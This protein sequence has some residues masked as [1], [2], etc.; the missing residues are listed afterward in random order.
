MLILNARDIENCAA[1]VDLV[2]AVEQAFLVQEDGAYTMPDRLHVEHGGN[3]L[4]AMPAFANDRFATKLVSVFPEST[5]A[6]QGALLLND[7]ADGRPLALMEGAVLT[8]LRTGAV[9]GLGIAHTT[10]AAAASLGLFGAGVQ[11]FRQVL[12]ACGVRP[13]GRVT[14]H[15]PHHP[16]LPGFLDRLRKRLP[17]VEF[18]VAEDARELVAASEIVI[19][20]TTSTTPVVPADP[21]LLAGRSYVGLGSFRPDMREFPDALME[22]L[23][24]VVVDTDLARSESGDLRIPLESGQLDSP[25][26]VRLGQ[27]IRGSDTLDPDGTTLFKTVG[28]ALCDLV[29]ARAL[30]RQ[31]LADGIGTTVAFP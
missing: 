18:G 23:D 24:R 2:A 11:G 25:K 9:S 8:A 15:D 7:G 1:A 12:F 6:I 16:D 27:V 17:G 22:V 28:M 5:P 21:A 14:V 19:T 30:H 10:P 4:L 29:V 31:A 20:A 13:I 26:I 3:V